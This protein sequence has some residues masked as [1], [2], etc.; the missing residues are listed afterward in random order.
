MSVLSYLLM[1]GQMLPRVEIYKDIL[2]NINYV[3]D[4][5]HWALKSMNVWRVKKVMLDSDGDA[6]SITET[7]GYDNVITDL[8][9]V[10]ALTY[11]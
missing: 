6:Y 1:T 9:T 10:Q 4:A 3:C 5:E 11:K 8:S 2:N 7:D